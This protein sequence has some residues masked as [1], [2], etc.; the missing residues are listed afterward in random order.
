MR[1]MAFLS[2]VTLLVLSFT[3]SSQP[4]ATAAVK[5]AFIYKVSRFTTWPE[6]L[7]TNN[8]EHFYFCFIEQGEE[9][10][11]EFLLKYK[12]ELETNDKPFAVNKRDV[13]IYQISKEND[14]GPK[15]HLL[16]V[17]TQGNPLASSWNWLNTSDTLT[18]GNSL[19]FLQ[20]GG[21]SALVI[22][23]GRL[24]LYVNRNNLKRSNLKLSSRVLK[25]ARFYPN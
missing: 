13:E 19:E 22:E 5:S 3:T 20:Q 21:I 15:C 7:F 25:H 11:S 23:N 4:A 1:M 12:T 24:R 9:K 18:I 16:Y 6:Q 10:P 17:D 2:L 14:Q 8:Q